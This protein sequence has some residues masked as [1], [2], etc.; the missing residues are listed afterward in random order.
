MYVCMYGIIMHVCMH[1]WCI[2]GI[3]TKIVACCMH[4]CDTPSHQ[5]WHTLFLSV[6]KKII[7]LVTHNIHS[8]DTF[9]HTQVPD[10]SSKS[11]H[12]HIQPQ[13]RENQVYTHIRYHTDTI[14]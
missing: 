2:N 8:R 13:S 9:A 11:A 14:M 10:T 5:R 6:I 1:V 4:V 12:I 3:K 7:S